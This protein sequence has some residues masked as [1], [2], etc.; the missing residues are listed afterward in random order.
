MAKHNKLSNNVFKTIEQEAR[1]ILAYRYYTILADDIPLHLVV[2]HIDIKWDYQLK[3]DT[4]LLS[5]HGRPIKWLHE[6]P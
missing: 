6:I 3:R 2:N 4:T 5:N 1:N